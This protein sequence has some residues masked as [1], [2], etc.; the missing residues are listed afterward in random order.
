MAANTIQQLTTANTFQH[1]LTA[2]QSLIG[3]ANNL[4][5]GAGDTFYANTRLEVG[6][7]GASLNVVTS[8][9]IEELYLNSLNLTG[10][11][12][13]LDVTSTANIGT[14]LTVY[15]NVSVSGDISGNISGTISGN[16]ALLTDV[17]VSNTNIDGLITSNQIESGITLPSSSGN[18]TYYLTTDGT[19][20]IWK[21]QTDL[22]ISTTL[23]VSSFNTTANGLTASF[24]LGFSPANE[25][26]VIVALDGILQLPNT[27]YT[28]SGSTITFDSTPN[29]TVTVH[30][31]LFS[32]S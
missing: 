20:P 29:D 30:V 13:T 11:I 9:T 6:G 25:D 23:S 24:N 22:D 12:S 4:T 5:N 2:T 28:V 14:D 21:A 3:V 27:A 8:A 19:Q 32:T 7:T 31:R 16:G 26:Y 10:N 1:W 17:V 15:G 18:T